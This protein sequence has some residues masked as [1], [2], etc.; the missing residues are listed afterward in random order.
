MQ[1]NESGL[2]RVWAALLGGSSKPVKEA[3]S[4]DVLQRLER[5][6]AQG[7][8]AAALATACFRIDL[9]EHEGRLAFYYVDDETYGFLPGDARKN[10]EMT[11]SLAEEY[12][13]TPKV[14]PKTIFSCVFD[15]YW[16]HNLAF[17][18]IDVGANVG[19]LAIDAGRLV[20]MAGRQ[21][22]LVAFEPGI[23]KSLL[24][25]NLELNG[26]ESLVRHEVL[27]VSNYDGLA[28]MLAEL[29]NSVNNRISIRDVATEWRSEVIRTVKLD[30]YCAKNDISEHLV[31]KIDTQGHD[32]KVLQG[33][34]ALRHDRLVTT[35]FEFTPWALRTYCDPVQ[36][37]TEL[38]KTNW[39]IDCK[40]HCVGPRVLVTDSVTGVTNADQPP[41]F[42]TDMM[43]IPRKLPEAEK[44]VSA[45]L[46]MRDQA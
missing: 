46:G 40:Q 3:V 2:R 26:L 4:E 18:F 11:A 38:L 35:L 41:G 23:Y 32:W 28:L 43:L 1:G 14:A 6:E 17:A 33:A 7:K 29:G 34:E 9:T 36:V 20:R 37:L 15:H 22:R 8:Q 42:W 16:A 44:L 12:R 27:A 39:V 45:I 19:T 25:Y 30:T 5:L 10:L 21:N 31:L 24:P 13:Q